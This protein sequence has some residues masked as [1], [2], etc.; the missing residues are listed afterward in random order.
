MA[1]TNRPDRSRQIPRNVCVVSLTSFFTDLSGKMII[2][3]LPLFLANALGVGTT[4]IR[5]L[6][7]PAS[8]IA[9]ALR[10]AISPGAP[11]FFGAALALI[12]AGALW[13]WKPQP[14]QS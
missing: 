1:T 10:D 14:A 6:R 7:L 13:I 12:A 2:N 4:V 3:L 5:G 8:V 9:G 11:F